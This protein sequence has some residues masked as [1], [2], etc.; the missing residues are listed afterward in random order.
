MVCGQ[1]PEPSYQTTNFV[2]QAETA[3]IAKVVAESAERNRQ[4][5]ARL[6]LEQDLP[7]W[8]FPCQIHVTIDLGR[9]AGRSD[10][11]FSEGAVISQ[12]IN[13]RGPLQRVLKG[14]LPH[15]LTHVL[16]AHYFGRQPPRWAD[17]GG[18]ILSEDAIQGDRQKILF[19]K[20]QAEDRCFALRQLLS[21]RDYPSDLPC[22]YAQ[23]HSVVRYLV[24]CKSRKA[25]LSFVSDGL[26]R[27]WDQA[28]RTQ[29]GYENVEQLEH[30]WLGWVAHQPQ[31]SA[32]A[33]ETRST[34]RI[35]PGR[36]TA[37]SRA[38]LAN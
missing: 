19:R 36:L 34:E 24:S 16:F 35:A 8:A 4:D 3:E 37:Y 17:E 11:S 21:M 1:N 9:T 31:P 32:A 38:L 18:A 22:L 5:F 33:A 14:P 7:D 10:V 26:D 23:G 20:I 28:V 13:V 30:A 25:F 29:Y 15:E 2:V 27:G 12:E 6:W